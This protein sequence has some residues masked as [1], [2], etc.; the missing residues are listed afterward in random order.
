M[1]S[2]FA[3]PGVP[4]R[5]SCSCR[6]N[7]SRIVILIELAVGKPRSAFF[8]M[9]RSSVR[10]TIA[11]PITPSNRSAISPMRACSFFQSKSSV[12]LAGADF[13]SPETLPAKAAATTTIVVATR[14]IRFRDFRAL[15]LI[16][17]ERTLECEERGIEM[18]ERL[19]QL[20]QLGRRPV[21]LDARET[22]HFHRLGQEPADILEMRKE[23]FSVFVCFA[24]EKLI[25]V[26][27]EFV[28]EHSLLR[29][30][31]GRQLR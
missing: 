15:R 21:H 17:F 11:T 3:F 7:S 10:S 1:S 25:A 31:L 22:G 18:C 12:P 29:R 20:F 13:C 9:A 28:E 2:S 8:R 26:P 14:V 6:Y 30:G 27:A 23:A 4:P 24:T 5:A 19:F 16:F